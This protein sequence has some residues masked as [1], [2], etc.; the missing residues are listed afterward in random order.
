MLSDTRGFGRTGNIITAI[1]KLVSRAHACKAKLI[2]PAQDR[3]ENVIEMRFEDSFFDFSKRKGSVHPA[4]KYKKS[5]I[6]FQGNVKKTYYLKDLR[7]DSVEENEFFENYDTE[8]EMLISCLKNYI[9]ICRDSYCSE[10]DPYLGENVLVAH[11]RQGDIFVDNMIQKSV[12]KIYGQ[13]PL[14]Y[15]LQAF[16][17]RDWDH[18]IILSNS[19]ESGMNPVWKI[20][21]LLNNTGLLS[22]KRIYFQNSDWKTDMKTLLC[23]KNIVESVSTFHNGLLLGNSIRWYTYLHCKHLDSLREYYHIDVDSTYT[24]MHNFERSPATYL[25]M[26][27]HDSASPKY[28]AFN[29]NNKSITIPR[30][31]FNLKNS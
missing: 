3:K 6:G 27:T 7:N 8:S 31:I 10:V 21:S 20:L 18:I 14:S 29:F 5:G 26:I 28:C 23:A 16:N 12:L 30:D 9:G 22:G 2:L 17:A 15:Y 19:P 11:I 1:M 13:P 4:C 24:P 25:D